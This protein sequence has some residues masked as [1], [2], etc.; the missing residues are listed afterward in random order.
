MALLKVPQFLYKKRFLDQG[1]PE[2]TKIAL[3][4]FNLS[5]FNRLCLT[6]GK[7]NT[8]GN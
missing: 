7:S 6:H 4:G 2:S 8:N 5:L 3:K 1:Q